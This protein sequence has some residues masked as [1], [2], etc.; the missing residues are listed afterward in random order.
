MSNT[1]TAQLPSIEQELAEKAIEFPLGLPGFPEHKKFVLNQ[2]PEE[3]PYAWLR[4]LDD[5]NLAF[6]IIEVYHLVPDYSFEVDDEDLAAI[7]M[8]Q[9]QTCAL[10][11]ILRIESDNGLKIHVNLKAPIVLNTA[12]RKGRQVILHPE[13]PYS[14]SSIFELKLK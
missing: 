1:S 7:G 5:P 3:K 2:L 10:F 11:F 4:S 6:P 13:T 14:D 8:P 9:P 12:E